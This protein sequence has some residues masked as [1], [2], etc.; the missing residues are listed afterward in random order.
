MRWV[1]YSMNVAKLNLYKQCLKGIKMRTYEEAVA[2]YEKCKSPTRSAKWLAMPDKPR[3]LRNVSAD[4]MGIHKT[5]EGAIYYRLYNTNVAIFYPPEANGDRKV[6]TNFYNSQT[7][8]I[9]MYENNLHYYEQVTT[10]GKQVKVPYVSSWDRDKQQHTPSAVLYFDSNN[11]LIVERSH[12]KDIYTFKSSAEDKEKRKEF[13]KKVDVLMTLAMFRLPEYRANVT[14]EQTLGEPF[15]TQYRNKPQSI[16]DFEHTVNKLGADATEH[17]E[18]IQHFLDMGQAVFNILA[19]KKVY[20]HI[21]EGERWEG[22]LFRTWNLTTEQKEELKKQQDAIIDQVTAEEF[23][24]S[25][26][27]RLLEIA[28]LKT[29]SVKTPWGQFM[30]TIPRKYYI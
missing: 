22:S 18:Y 14:V 9:F 21:P 5:D 23:K 17:P 3:Y 28:S 12:H 26:T 4:H 11:K 30:D 25:L 2:H 27:T 8:S 20:S 7:T 16:D 24:K 15:G 1:G 19:S 29:G 13:K 6:V 10:D